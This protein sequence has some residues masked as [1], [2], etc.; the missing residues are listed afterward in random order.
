MFFH[1]SWKSKGLWSSSKVQ[2]PGQPKVLPFHLNG[3]MNH[4]VNK[5]KKNKKNKNRNNNWP[6]T[7]TYRSRV[8]TLA[9]ELIRFYDLKVNQQDQPSVLSPKN[10]SSQS[11][12]KIKR[13]SKMKRG[14]KTK[15]KRKIEPKENTHHYSFLLPS[16]S[17]W[18]Q[19]S[20]YLFI[21]LH[22]V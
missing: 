13:N 9:Y 20:I 1:K 5:N 7:K 3:E 6:Q 15:I 17:H 19:C 21:Y 4:K 2:F 10:P 11:W 18:Y 16:L 8:Q 12:I 22:D 14:R